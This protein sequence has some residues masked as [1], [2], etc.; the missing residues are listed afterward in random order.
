LDRTEHLPVIL[1][2]SVGI[3]F[4]SLIGI[5]TYFPV[6]FSMNDT[7]LGGFPDDIQII[8]ITQKDLEQK[9]PVLKKGQDFLADQKQSGIAEPIPFGTNIPI[10]EANE[11]RNELPFVELSHPDQNFRG[12]YLVIE[13]VAEENDNDDNIRS[14]Q[15]RMYGIGLYY[16]RLF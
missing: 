15:I 7:A 9:F 13:V 5:T 1:G 11:M 4:I 6:T 12:Y 16:L 8:R 10:L 2:L 14:A 3:G